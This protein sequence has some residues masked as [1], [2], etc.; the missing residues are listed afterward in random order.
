MVFGSAIKHTRSYQAYA[1][2]VAILA[3]G[4][5]TGVVK[6]EPTPE[7]VVEA[8]AADLAQGYLAAKSSSQ[9]LNRLVKSG[10]FSGSGPRFV[11]KVRGETIDKDNVDEY[12]AKYQKQLSFHEEAIKQRGFTTVAGQYKGEATEACKRSNA[13]WAALIQRQQYRAI[14]ITQSEMDAQVSITVEHKGKDVDMKNSAAVAES[15]MALIEA[16]NS[17]YYFRGEIKDNVIVFK[18]D[19]SVLRTWPKWANPPS[20]SDLEDCVVTLERI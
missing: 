1:V 16:S 5:S 15:A 14:E 12:V 18:P 10:A 8:P 20:P 6:E 17:D 11:V 9:G 19:L 2:F 3:T 13:M 7:D 4:C